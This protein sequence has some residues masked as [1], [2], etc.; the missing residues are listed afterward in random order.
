M[1]MNSLPSGSWSHF[2][3]HR[4]T[5][6]SLTMLVPWCLWM[7][8]SCAPSKYWRYCWLS[9]TYFAVVWYTSSVTE[10]KILKT[11]CHRYCGW[12]ILVCGKYGLRFSTTV[13]M[14]NIAYCKLH[15]LS[16]T[17]FCNN[18]VHFACRW[19]CLSFIDLKKKF[20]AFSWGTSMFIQHIKVQFSVSSFRITVRFDELVDLITHSPH[21]NK[22][23]F[24]PC[25]SLLNTAKCV[26]WKTVCSWKA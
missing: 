8:H 15:I 13:I 25:Q 17:R 20:S 19:Q 21:V 16:N 9:V 2:S 14:L 22:K 26:T 1:V 3:Q 23:H 24:S 12:W 4:T 6:A 18:I 11:L 10:D 7:K 5:V